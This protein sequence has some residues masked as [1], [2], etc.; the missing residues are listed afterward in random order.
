MVGVSDGVL[1]HRGVGLGRRVEGRRHAVAGLTAIVAV[2]VVHGAVWIISCVGGTRIGAKLRPN[3]WFCVKVTSGHISF[4]RTFH[5]A[6]TLRQSL[7]VGEA[8]HMSPVAMHLSTSTRRFRDILVCF[9]CS[10]SMTGT[11]SVGLP[12]DSSCLQQQN[13]SSEKISPGII[14]IFSSGQAANPRGDGLL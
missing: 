13:G 11:H 9:M 12:I 10:V 1:V 7:R 3:S 14:D 4:W 6:I 2:S 8:N 5:E